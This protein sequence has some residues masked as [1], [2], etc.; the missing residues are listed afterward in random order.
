MN[1]YIV[2]TPIGN[3]QDITIRAAKT[4]LEAQ[5]IVTESTSK[6]GILIQFLKEQFPNISY[7]EKSI[8]SMTEDE[9]E[10]KLPQIIKILGEND[11]V[12]TSEAGTPL[13][14]DPGF[15]LV[16]EA[17]KRGANIISIPGASAVIS[18]LTSSGLPTDKFIFL[19]YLPKKDSKI[20]EIL[21]IAQKLKSETSIT[22]IFFDSPHRIIENLKKINGQFGNIDIVIAR[23]LTKAHEEIL[24]D[25]VE[26]LI[27]HFEEKSPKGEFVILI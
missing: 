7:K 19:G 5:V 13:V 24:R 17:V 16:R 27:K 3:L 23:E 21:T 4:I 8:I 11:V 22:L 2:A 9:E 6:T 18:A 14:S 12:L 1:L 20:N 15:R 25:K 10:N 26:E